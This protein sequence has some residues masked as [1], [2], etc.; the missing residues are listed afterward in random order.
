M[1]TARSVI[2]RSGA[3]RRSIPGPRWVDGFVSLAMALALV[4]STL[5]LAF[6]FPALTGRVVDQAN[7]IPAATRA[8]I[9][10]K[11]ASLEDKSGI[12]LVV[13][14]VSSL[15]GSDI[16]TYSVDLARAWKIGEAKKKI[17]HSDS[18]HR[19]AE[20]ARAA[21]KQHDYRALAEEAQA[22][23]AALAR[24]NYR[25]QA[26]ISE[27]EEMLRGRDSVIQGMKDRVKPV[28]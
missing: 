4:W 17:E 8:Q 7:I 23:A 16:E 10:R 5:A 15:E 3:T 6:N 12:Q 13:A 26:R 24:I 22:E 25:L 28:R 9:E 27:L 18:K 19:R 20:Q 2:A 21:A 11:L 14:T 1:L